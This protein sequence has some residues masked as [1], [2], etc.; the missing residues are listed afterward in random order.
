[1]EDPGIEI[2]KIRDVAKLLKNTFLIVGLLLLS[3]T[4]ILGREG[5]SMTLHSPT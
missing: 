4:W 5:K 3:H 1:M 2:Q